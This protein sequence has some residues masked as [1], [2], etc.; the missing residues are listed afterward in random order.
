MLKINRDR[1]VFTKY[2]LQIG[3][4]IKF[5]RRK[6]SVEESHRSKCSQFCVNEII[7]LRTFINLGLFQMSLL[8]LPL[9]TKL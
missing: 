9:L 1:Y 5:Y 3:K 6:L 7:C 8:T 4:N 2:E